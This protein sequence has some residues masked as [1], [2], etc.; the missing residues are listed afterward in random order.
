MQR[1]VKA[2]FRNL[3]FL[4]FLWT[5]S[6]AVASSTRDEITDASPILVT[7]DDE[8]TDTG[9]DSD[10]DT[11][12]DADSDSDGDSDSD[13]D[14]D[15][16]TD[17]DSDTD[18][19]ADTDTD[20]DTDTDADTD[21][22]SDANLYPCTGA[23]ES[24]YSGRCYRYVSTA[25]DFDLAEAD[26]IAWGGHLASISDAGENSH[27][28]SM[29]GNDAWIGLSN[30][31]TSEVAVTAAENDHC[32]NMT[33]M[34]D[35]YGGRVTGSNS[36]YASQF[37]PDPGCSTCSGGYD[38]LFP[39]TVTESGFWIFSLVDSD[40]DTVLAVVS[41]DSAAGESECIGAAVLCSDPSDVYSAL[42]PG[43]YVVIVDGCSSDTVG[44]YVL[45]VRRFVFL[46]GSSFTWDNWNDDE[47]NDS[48][49]VEDC[50]ELRSSGGRWNDLPCSELRPYVCERYR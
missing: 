2:F 38:V 12:N 27:I 40:F 41:R 9:G 31:G 22:D 34:I 35:L 28:Y 46:D 47:P 13:T 48:G 32:D 24:I 50:V 1:V 19:D 39:L 15:S 37:D 18:A 4:L 14:T 3:P 8:G 20:S 29:V 49:R 7:D 30:L 16:D 5:V 26:C 10:T 17:G 43:E 25:A 45:D 44:N 42:V 21:T 33:T 23:G 11:D 36:S 6:C